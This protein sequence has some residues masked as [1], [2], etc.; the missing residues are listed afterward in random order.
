MA[1]RGRES[2]VH[3]FSAG[4]FA[5]FSGFS[6]CVGC[7]GLV[8]RHGGVASR[9]RGSNSCFT[10]CI[11]IC[12]ADCA[13]SP[14][15]IGGGLCCPYWTQPPGTWPGP[16]YPTGARTSVARSSPSGRQGAGALTKQF[17][18]AADMGNRDALAGMVQFE[19]FK[20][21]QKL[22]RSTDEDAPSKTATIVSA[23]RRQKAPRARNKRQPEFVV[24]EWLDIVQGIVCIW[25]GQFFHPAGLWKSTKAFNKQ[26][27][28]R[29]EH[30]LSQDLGRGQ[31]DRGRAPLAQ[32]GKR[33]GRPRRIGDSR[34]W[35][36]SSPGP[37]T[38]SGSASAS[39]WHTSWRFRRALPSPKPTEL[40]EKFG[41]TLAQETTKD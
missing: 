26:K 41:K 31:I 39:G 22:N 6:C 14:G 29:R 16:W 15:I 24:S 5:S 8:G 4:A 11:A 37:P 25:E 32:T 12:L 13:D 35:R 38:R 18:A 30:V 33:S 9:T 20:Q 34:Q 3:G 27:G 10:R 36:G 19:V 7:R 23:F 21:L 1:R 28:F 2:A 40:K 17:Q